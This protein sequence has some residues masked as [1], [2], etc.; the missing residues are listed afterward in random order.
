MTAGTEEESHTRQG[1]YAKV[2]Y[3][4]MDLDPERLRWSEEVSRIR[5][6]PAD[7][8]PTLEAGLQFYHP[9]DRPIIE[10]AVRRLKET[11]E[12]YDLELREL[13]DEGEV[14][15]VR[16]TGVPQYSDVGEIVKISG[17]YREITAEKERQQELAEI[18][19]KLQMSNQ[20]LEEFASLVSHDLRSPLNVAKGRLELA[21]ETCD[22]EHLA[23]A[24]RALTRMEALISDILTLAREGKVV[25]AVE[26]VALSELVQESWSVMDT[27]NATLEVEATRTVQA[28][29]ARLQQLVE[30]LIRN[31][32]DHGGDDVT[33]WIGD[34]DGGLY[35]EDD[36]P[37]IAE[38]DRE[39]VFESGYSTARDGTGF[40]LAI[41]KEIATAHGWEVN[42]T[43]RT[44]GGVRFEITGVET[45]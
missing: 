15:W 2:G 19:R 23:V 45:E 27:A 9:E 29:P 24:E 14:Y 7:Y 31:A 32:I 5:D 40:G 18:Q 17:V 13:T 42:V 21:A 25:D 36:G 38:P 37:G 41:V 4:E 30:N 6:L 44:G 33:I 11:G 35:V 12:T 8:T 1:E 28:D 20:Q 3:W 43:E 16:T 34:F 10:A 39:T 22:S 26:A